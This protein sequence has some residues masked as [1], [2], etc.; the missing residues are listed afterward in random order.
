VTFY[1]DK[2]EVIPELDYP[3]LVAITVETFTAHRAYTLARRYREKGIPVVMGGYHPTLCPDEALKYSTAIA[4]GDAET[5]WP[6]ILEDWQ[7]GKLQKIYKSEDCSTHLQTEFDRSI[8]AGKKYAPINLTQ[9]GRGCPNNCDF[10]SI[11]AF[12]GNRQSLRP[13]DAVMSDVAGFGKGTVFFVDDNIFHDKQ[14]LTLFLNELTP[15]K[16]KWVCQISIDAARDKGLM[17]L[18]EK[19]GCIAA[20][21]G[22][23]SLN[24]KN[25]RQMKKQW[26]MA[27][28]DYATAVEVFRDHGIMIYGTFVFGYDHDTPDAFDVCLDFALKSRFLLANFNPLTPTPGT[29]LYNRLLKE[30]RLIYPQ[31]WNDPDYRYGE[32]IF[33]PKMMTADQLTDGCFR[34]R[35]AFNRYSSIFSR[36]FDLKAN[37]KSPGNLSK[38]ILANLLNRKEMH[39]K[40]GQRLGV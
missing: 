7:K 21:I 4:I 22:F 40:Q 1:D 17:K 28:N 27:G 36:M 35:A 31:W 3:D 37:F 39:K 20:I 9:W 34:V 19:S 25:L 26:N 32:A 11:N 5:I 8:F 15:L 14:Q 2:V 12:Y 24:E 18:L 23:E 13:I 33:R 30:D 6:T 38:Y 10:C 16:V 29:A